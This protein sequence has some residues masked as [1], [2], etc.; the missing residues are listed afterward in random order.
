MFWGKQDWDQWCQMSLVLASWNCSHW[1]RKFANDGKIYAK[2]FWRVVLKER[3]SDDWKLQLW[4]LK[5]LLI[6]EHQLRESKTSQVR[7]DVKLAKVLN[8]KWDFSNLS[9]CFVHKTI[10]RRDN[11]RRS[12]SLILKLAW[13][14]LLMA[15]NVISS[16]VLWHWTCKNMQK[17]MRLKSFQRITT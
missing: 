12:L 8:C 10:V 11:R 13:D 7:F 6:N 5:T 14:V 15:S 3:F 2:P 16:C 9:V 17:Q 1:C 4:S